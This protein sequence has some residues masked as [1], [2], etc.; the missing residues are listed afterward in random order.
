[1]LPFLNRNSE[2][3]VVTVL[4]SKYALAKCGIDGCSNIPAL[5][6]TVAPKG[7]DKEDFGVDI[8]W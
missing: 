8:R 1:M 3:A 2:F 7:V 5:P 6:I 4:L